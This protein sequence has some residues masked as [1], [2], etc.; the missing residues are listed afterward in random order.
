[1][2]KQAPVEFVPKAKVAAEHHVVVKTIDRWTAN[3]KMGFPQPVRIN[4]RDYFKRGELERWKAAQRAREVA[5]E[6]ETA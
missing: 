5:A 4:R 2:A 1:M 6:L 3:P